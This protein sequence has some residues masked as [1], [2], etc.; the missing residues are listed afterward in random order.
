MIPGSTFFS[1]TATSDFLTQA[2]ARYT[3]ITFPHAYAPSTAVASGI[4]GVSVSVDSTDDS[5]PQVET[6]ETYQ[7]VIPSEGAATI[8]AATVY[9]ALRGLE[10]FSQLVTFDFESGTYSIVST[11][12]NIQDKPRFPHRGLMIDTARHFQ[13][14]ASIKMMIDSL[15]YAK[16]NVLH[17]WVASSVSA[18]TAYTAHTLVPL[19]DHSL[20]FVS[21][22]FMT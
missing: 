10:T 12:W 19:L 21:L 20:C 15:Q 7:L 9:G 13:T 2:F 22:V 11:P 16:I 17:W 14:L 3:D 6:D 5:H 1:T 18:S 4:T 8:K